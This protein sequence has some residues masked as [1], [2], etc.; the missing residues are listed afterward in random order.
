MY[1]I[2]L[3]YNYCS[4]KCANLMTYCTAP[5]DL[6]MPAHAEIVVVLPNF[7]EDMGSFIFFFRMTVTS[8]LK[9]GLYNNS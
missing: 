6:G 1:L 4:A 3:S 5:G 9:T 7:E 2:T 8:N